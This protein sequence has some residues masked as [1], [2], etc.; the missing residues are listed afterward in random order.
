L[1]V[2]NLEGFEKIFISCCTKCKKHAKRRVSNLT[3]LF[4][5]MRTC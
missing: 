2:P 3:V 4:Q 5:V 1:S